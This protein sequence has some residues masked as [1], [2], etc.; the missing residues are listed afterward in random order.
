MF[1]DAMLEHLRKVGIPKDDFRAIPMGV[2]WERWAERLQPHAL[3]IQ[4]LQQIADGG[5]TRDLL[6]ELRN[7]AE[8]AKWAEEPTLQFFLAVMVWGYTGDNRGPWRTANALANAERVVGSLGMAGQRLIDPDAPTDGRLPT[9]F[10]VFQKKATKIPWVSVSFFTKLMYFLGYDQM[11]D[12]QPRPLILDQRVCLGLMRHAV[13]CRDA[14]TLMTFTPT[15]SP[16]GY[17]QYCH[18]MHD[19][20]RA[21]GVEPDRLESFFFGEGE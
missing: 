6:F 5:L 13:P 20:A 21:L 9:A 10:Q 1:Y 8:A 4:N 14:E 2:D 18:W 16:E 15:D 12:A 19:W 3:L 7:Q 17:A 11:S